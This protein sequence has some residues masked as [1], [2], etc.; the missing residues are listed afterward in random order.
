LENSAG[1]GG[2]QQVPGY[3]RRHDEEM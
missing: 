3:L 2:A 1:A